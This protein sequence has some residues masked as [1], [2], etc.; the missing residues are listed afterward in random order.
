MRCSV[1][2]W[3]VE[4]VCQGQLFDGL[5]EDEA[6]FDSESFVPKRSVR[7]L[8]IKSNKQTGSSQGYS[9]PSFLSTDDVAG[10]THPSVPSGR[11]SRHRWALIWYCASVALFVQ[12]K[13]CFKKK[14]IRVSVHCLSLKEVIC[15]LAQ[16]SFLATFKVKADSR[17]LR[18]FL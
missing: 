11:D 17:S 4:C 16:C 6:S 1:L 8:V 15:R 9:P 13:H 14:P 18:D 10:R 2:W 7:S 3:V 12:C 5:E